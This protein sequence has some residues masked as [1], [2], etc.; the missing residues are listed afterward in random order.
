MKAL[1]FFLVAVPIGALFAAVLAAM[2]EQFGWRIA[3]LLW[4]I[5]ILLVACV[6][7]GMVLIVGP[8]NL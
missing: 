8:E 5:P 3:L 2:S 7:V 6:V 4:A 1:G